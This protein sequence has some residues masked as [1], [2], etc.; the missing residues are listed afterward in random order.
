MTSEAWLFLGF[1]IAWVIAVLVIVITLMKADKTG[2]LAPGWRVR[3]ATCGRAKPANEL[4]MICLGRI[5]SKPML[6]TCHGCERLRFAILE[7]DP[8]YQQEPSAA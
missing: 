4:G 6:V 1:G 8:E 3:C 5:G 2:N 7:K